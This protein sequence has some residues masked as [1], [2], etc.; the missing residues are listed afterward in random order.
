MGQTDSSLPSQETNTTM[1]EAAPAPVPTQAPV[2]K[3][4]PVETKAAVPEGCCQKFIL[5]T[6]IEKE[7]ACVSDRNQPNQPTGTRY[8]R[9]V[10]GYQ[11]NRDQYHLVRSVPV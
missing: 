8:L 9:H 2:E 7:K 6:D 3:P 11:P 1:A 10:T 5:N 4:A